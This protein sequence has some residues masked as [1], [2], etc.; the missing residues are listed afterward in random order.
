MKDK[1]TWLDLGVYFEDEA[2]FQMNSTRVRGGNENRSSNGRC[3]FTRLGW[4]KALEEK[5][6]IYG[7]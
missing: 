7:I 5:F 2:G 1:K 4:E 3:H 6:R